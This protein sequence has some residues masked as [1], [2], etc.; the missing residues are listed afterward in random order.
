MKLSI[1]LSAV[2]SEDYILSY[3]ITDTIFYCCIW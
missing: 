2:S 3:K 1:D